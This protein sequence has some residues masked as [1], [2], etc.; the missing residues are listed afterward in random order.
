M[1][2]A[3]SLLFLWSHCCFIHLSPEDISVLPVEKK[4]EKYLKLEIFYYYCLLG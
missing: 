2:S 3:A 4:T 1:L